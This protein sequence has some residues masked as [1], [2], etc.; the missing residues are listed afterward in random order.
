MISIS[1]KG[2]SVQSF[3]RMPLG[4]TAFWRDKILE[5]VPSR[6]VLGTMMMVGWMV[7]WTWGIHWE[8][9]DVEV[10]IALEEFVRGRLGRDGRRLDEGCGLSHPDRVRAA[11]RRAEAWGLVE[12]A[13]QSGQASRWRLR[14]QPRGASEEE[15]PRRSG[16]AAFTAD[17]F[18]ADLRWH[19][20]RRRLPPALVLMTEALMEATFSAPRRPRAWRTAAELIAETG[21]SRSVVW[22]MIARGLREG[23]FVRRPGP[24]GAAAAVALHLEGDRVGPDG[25]LLE[26]APAAGNGASPDG[27]AGADD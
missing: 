11:L 9:P 27:A 8:R 2:F 23:L 6:H 25:V 5:G 4:W 19:A 21:L 10:S 7:R 20:L 1:E 3:Y 18:A 24:P 16:F 14:I 15:D 22:D 17:Y 26:E 13:E 12:R